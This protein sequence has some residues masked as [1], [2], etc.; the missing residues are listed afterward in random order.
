MKTWLS[1]IG[2]VAA[3][4]IAALV[5]TSAAQPAS[6]GHPASCR[7][8]GGCLFETVWWPFC[9]KLRDMLACNDIRYTGLYSVLA[10]YS[11]GPG[12]PSIAAALLSGTFV[13]LVSR[14]RAHAIHVERF[15]GSLLVVAGIAAL[16]RTLPYASA[17]LVATFPLLERVG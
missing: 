11:L 3:S 1:R 9:R 8:H 17:W 12:V 5:P 7:D 6:A 14:L 4:A 2:V 13:A 15:V 10:V 16:T